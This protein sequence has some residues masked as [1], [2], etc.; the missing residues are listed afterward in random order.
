MSPGCSSSTVAVS[1]L[2]FFG[3]SGLVF[4]GVS[5]PNF[6]EDEEDGSSHQ[7]ILFNQSRV[8]G[9]IAGLAFKIFSICK[10]M[11]RY[12]VSSDCFAWWSAFASCVN[13]AFA[14]G[15]M[16]VLRRGQT[17]TSSTS[18]REHFSLSQNG[19]GART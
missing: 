7:F 9:K 11:P 17:S 12:L 13:L 5:G 1:G 3:V 10:R 16:L 8:S 14:L 19:Y 4:V 18:L 2:V 6:F 15:A